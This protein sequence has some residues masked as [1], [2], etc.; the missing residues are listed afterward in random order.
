M[1]THIDAWNMAWGWLAEEMIG[2]AN[3]WL[4]G[5]WKSQTWLEFTFN[6]KVYLPRWYF[7]CKHTC[8]YV[9]Y[10]VF[11]SFIFMLVIWCL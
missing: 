8:F 9:V 1:T 2:L 11:I 4:G 5:M 6:N 10:M 3:L 7:M